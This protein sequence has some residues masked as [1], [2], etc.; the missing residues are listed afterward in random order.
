MDVYGGKI[1]GRQMP[2]TARQLV[3][4]VESFKRTKGFDNAIARNAP[5]L[6]SLNHERIARVDEQSAT[7]RV[8]LEANERVLLKIRQHF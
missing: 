7:Q 4:V 5:L 3:A 8:A 1:H 6:A 2:L